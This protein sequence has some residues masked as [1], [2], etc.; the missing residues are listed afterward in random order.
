MKSVLVKCVFEKK[1]NETGCDITF[2]N[3]SNEDYE[4]FF[5]RIGEFDFS[6]KSHDNMYNRNFDQSFVEGVL[7]LTARSLDCKFSKRGGYWNDN[8]STSFYTILR[9]DR[10]M[11]RVEGRAPDF[12]DL[13]RTLD[14]TLAEIE[15]NMRGINDPSVRD[16]R[17][18]QVQASVKALRCYTDN[19]N[20]DAPDEIPAEA[21]ETTLRQVRD[22]ETMI[23]V[24]DTLQKLFGSAAKL[25]EA[26]LKYF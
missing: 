4:K 7:K 14:K 8:I 26:I 23:R 15:E 19:D 21:V 20:E 24:G 6:S 18:R 11:T 13:L 12:F 10:G 25:L 16:A 22:A 1:N 2:A 17:F 3:V 9:Q 5:K